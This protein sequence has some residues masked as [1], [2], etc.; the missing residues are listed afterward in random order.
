M[1]SISTQLPSLTD[2]EA[3]AEIVYETMAPTPQYR[4]PLLEERAGGEVWVKHENHAPTGAFKVRGGLVYLQMLRGGK[5]RIEGIVTATRGNHGQSIAMAARAT[6]IPVLVLVPHNNAADKNAAMR[7]LG[8]EVVEFGSDF[9]EA[10]EEA[11][12]VAAKRG[13]HRLSTFHPKLVGGVGTYTLELLR[14]VPQVETL[15]VPIGQ[16]SGICGAIAARNA[17]SHEAEIVGVV[18]AGAPA[19]ARSLEAGKSISCPVTTE[20][21]DGMACRTP[22]ESA[23]RI[24]AD[25]GIRIVEVSDEQIADAIRLLFAT[26]HNVAEGAG[27]AATAAMLADKGLKRNGPRAVVLSGQNIDSGVLGKILSRAEAPAN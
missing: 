10:A 21:A 3:A 16:G 13:W 2:L 18:S 9:Q 22:N 11:D 23:L 17:L 27:A 19:Y 12:R 7:A 20:L 8:G 1:T 6:G 24:I 26:T 5:P 15:Y 25:A 14:T 4:W